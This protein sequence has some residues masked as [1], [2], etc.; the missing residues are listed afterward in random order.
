M[1]LRK[2]SN[3]VTS[4]ANEEETI[5]L[6]ISEGE[7]YGL[8]GVHKEIWDNFNKDFFEKTLIVEEFLSNFDNPK[9]EIQKL[10][11]ASVKDLINY[12]LL[13]VVD[14]NE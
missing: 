5:V 8:E 2:N 4:S 12:K 7:Y 14:K 9:E 3:T 1:L 6:H 13:L 10:V 11:D